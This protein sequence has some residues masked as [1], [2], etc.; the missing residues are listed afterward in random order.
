MMT[1]HF[2]DHAFLLSSKVAIMKDNK[3]LA[4]G[5]PDEV[6]TEDRMEKIYGV[7]VKIMDVET[8]VKRRIC[9]P[10]GDDDARSGRK[11]PFW[12]R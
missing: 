4:V 2:P 5:S 6:I 9:V 12:R 11:L 7:K 10:L 8:P 1:S 3:F